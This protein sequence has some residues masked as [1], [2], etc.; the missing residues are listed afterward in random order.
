MDMHCS[1]NTL[2]LESEKHAELA[3]HR[4]D[5]FEKAEH[6]CRSTLKNNP[7][8]PECLHLLGVLLFQKGELEN[9]KSLLKK[10]ICQN[11]ENP[12]FH[13]SMGNV[14]KSDGNLKNQ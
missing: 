3:Y 11:P 8:N 1:Q 12:K 4:M 9:A 2:K 14:Y 6:I 5:D 10:A 13:I 7:H